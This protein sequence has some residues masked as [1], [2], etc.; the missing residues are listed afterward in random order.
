MDQYRALGFPGA[1]EIGNMFEFYVR[2]KPDRDKE[3]TKKLNCDVRRF[4]V[5]VQENKDMLDEAFS[6]I[7]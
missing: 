5:W 3:L 1:L 2:G 7:E 4:E 6:K